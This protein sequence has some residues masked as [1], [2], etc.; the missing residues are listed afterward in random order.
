[1][2][3][4]GATR[5]VLDLFQLGPQPPQSGGDP[6][7]GLGR[8]RPALPE[9]ALPELAQPAV[10]A[11]GGQDRTHG[12]GGEQYDERQ[13]RELAH[14]VKCRPGGRAHAR[15]RLAAERRKAGP[16]RR[17]AGSPGRTRTARPAVRSIVCG[18]SSGPITE[19]TD[20]TECALTAK[21]TRSCSPSSGGSAEARTGAVT[22]RPPNSVP[23]AV[24]AQRR[25]RDPAGQ[26][27][28]FHACG[29]Q[30]GSDEPADCPSAQDARAHQ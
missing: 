29:G 8:E 6:V 17:R 14:V 13:Q 11:R 5:L 3:F 1:M 7:D 24:G 22:G 19:A 25:K 30:P 28:R 4:G 9:P 27:R 20:G 18:P 15:R 12:Q 10:A 26:R 16:S 21:T 2:P 23:R